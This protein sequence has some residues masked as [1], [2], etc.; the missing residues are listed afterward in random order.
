MREG[1]KSL[2]LGYRSAQ[3]AKKSNLIRSASIPAPEQ[4][5]ERDNSATYRLKTS[6][7]RLRK[8]MLM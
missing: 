6:A 2:N 3:I 1:A 4:G 5:V 8:V 7:F